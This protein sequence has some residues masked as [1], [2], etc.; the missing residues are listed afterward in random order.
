M[1]N[2]ESRD[3]DDIVYVEDK[4]KTEF[5]EV[6]YPVAKLIAAIKETALVE[7]LIEVF[8]IGRGYFMIKER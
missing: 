3:I 8:E 1:K 2:I 7:E 4:V 6:F 5:I